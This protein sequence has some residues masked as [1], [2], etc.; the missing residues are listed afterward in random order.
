MAK[1]L[2][3]GN[4]VL[5][6]AAAGAIFMASSMMNSPLPMYAMHIGGNNMS[7]GM[8]TGLFALSSC[9]CRPIFGNL[10]DKKGRCLILISGIIVYGLLTFSYSWTTTIFS[11]LVVRFLQG[12]GMSAYSTS[13]GTVAADLIPTERLVDGFGYYSLIQT[14]SGSFGPMLGL[15]LVAGSSYHAL[16][17]IA[18]AF[19][20]AGLI[21]ALFLKY[22]KKDSRHFSLE[23][24]EIIK[25]KKKA[26]VFEKSAVPITVAVFFISIT[27]GTVMTFIM[28]FASSRGIESIGI[29]F[30]FNAAVVFLSRMF[31]SKLVR[32]LKI[33][34]TIS[35]GLL[36][37]AAS[38]VTLYFADVLYLFLL[39]AI[40]NGLGSGVLFPVFNSLV[41]GFCPKE[42]KGAANATYYVGIDIGIGV[43]SVIGGVIS[44]K[45]GYASLYILSAVCA[46]VA[47]LIYH[48]AIRGSLPGNKQ[49]KIVQDMV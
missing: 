7:A 13:L 1:K 30:T 15:Y 39:A 34:G 14:F 25:V 37:L 2:W 28:P 3:T 44:Q 33:S 23:P 22:E 16:F 12:A 5:F 31:L 40:L 46:V 6:I 19:S 35:A 18:T 49:S 26:G 20:F 47:Y 24:S 11:L 17:Y 27:T 36:F 41:V 38:M 21:I 32:L 8:V 45:A 48:S 10:L 29:Y 42:R 9:I 43:G 4:F